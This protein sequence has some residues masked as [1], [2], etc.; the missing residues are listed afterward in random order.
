MVHAKI[1]SRLSFVKPRQWPRLP[2]AQSGALIMDRDHME[3][4][5]TLR[6]LER[7]IDDAIE[8]LDEALDTG[9]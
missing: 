4:E 2:L 7:L 9:E 3:T 1:T 6:D 5:L 8:A